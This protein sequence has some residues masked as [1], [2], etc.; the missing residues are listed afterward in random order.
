MRRINS[1]LG[2]GRSLFEAADFPA[3]GV[4]KSLQLFDWE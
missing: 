1:L 4:G 2:S 3:P